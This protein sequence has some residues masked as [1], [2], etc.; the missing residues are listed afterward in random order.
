[1][2]GTRDILSP[3]DTSRPAVVPKGQPMSL[4]MHQRQ[5]VAGQFVQWHFALDNK[6]GLY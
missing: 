1:M 5:G 2:M 6:R 4:E 3:D